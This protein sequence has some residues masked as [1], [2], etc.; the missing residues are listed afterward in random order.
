MTN[1]LRDLFAEDMSDE[2][3]HHIWHFLSELVLAFEAIHYGQIRRYNKSRTELY[4]ELRNQNEELV[5]QNSD[6]SINAEKELQ[7]PP[8]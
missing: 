6:Q 4:N 2:T 1:N 8:F 7:D 3:A 5:K